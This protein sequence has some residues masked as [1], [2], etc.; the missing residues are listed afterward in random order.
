[1]KRW[2]IRHNGIITVKI[3]LWGQIFGKNWIPLKC[4]SA[5]DF[6][7]SSLEHEK[8]GLSL[9]ESEREEACIDSWSIHDKWL[10]EKIIDRSLI[11]ESSMYTYNKG[12]KIKCCIDM[13][14]WGLVC[15]L[16]TFEAQLISPDLFKNYKNV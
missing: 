9:L 4:I 8:A 12:N 7:W 11:L 15:C 6:L 2:G 1:M 5:L 14:E 3:F 13:G 16:W 10:F